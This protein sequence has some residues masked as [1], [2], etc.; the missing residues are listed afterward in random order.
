MRQNHAP[1]RQRL[2]AA[3]IGLAAAAAVAAGGQAA[4]E[5]RD[6][7]TA[8]SI[9]RAGGNTYGFVAG[10]AFVSHRREVEIGGDGVLHFPG[11]AAVMDAATV[12]VHSV[13]D[14][15]GTSVVE[16]RFAANL[17]TPEALLARQ[18][19]KSVTVVLA[20]GEVSGTL[21]AVSLEALVV[22]TADHGL[23]IIRRGEHVV[24]IKLGAAR[25]DHEPTLEWKLAVRRPGKHTIEVS[26]RTYGWSWVP[27]Y[28]AVLADGDAIDFTAWA[29]VRN[30]SGLDLVA[31]TLTLVSESPVAAVAGGFVVGPARAPVPFEIGRPVDLSTGLA[32]QVELAP[33]RTGVKARRV[34]VFEAVGDQSSAYPLQ[35]CYGYTPPATGARTEQMLE[36]E[37]PGRILP[38]GTVRVFRRAA[39]GGLTIVGEDSL[40]VNATTGGLRVRAGVA[41]EITGE[42]RQLDCRVDPGGRSLRERV[43]L[44]IENKGKVAV[45]VIAREYMY[46]WSNWRMDQEDEKG[47]RAGGSAQEWRV[48]L[49]S[50]GS[51]TLTYTVVYAW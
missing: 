18:V 43:E 10:G 38:E 4:A 46:R 11:V 16:Q 34:S 3:T 51:K 30:D 39:S 37:G 1:A 41:P 7:R 19:G 36:L 32:L 33:K 13:T 28:T 40:R 24:D 23:E 22:E 2:V 15:A 44:K 45:D 26:Y 47:Q 42:R 48:R 21:R 50:G 20:Q 9:W 5:R 35:D 27:E 14:P 31:G 17:A 25:F 29:T 49:P 6:A 8:V 12:E